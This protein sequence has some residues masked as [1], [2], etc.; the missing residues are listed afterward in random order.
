MLLA[1]A[2]LACTPEIES[3]EAG[4]LDLAQLTPDQYE[5][6][7]VL[8]DDDGTTPTVGGEPLLLV[9]ELRGIGIAVWELPAGV[10]TLDAL[11]ALRRQ[12]HFEVVEPDLYR[13]GGALEVDDPYYAYQWSF[14]T[15]GMDDA[16]TRATG[17]GV[18]VA[19]ID[20]GIGVA[21]SDTPNVAMG[22][23]FV[24]EDPLPIDEHR[25][26]THVAG[27][28]AQ[29]TGNGVGTAGIA[30][31]AVVMPL[32]VLDADNRGR[33]SDIAAAL[34]WAAD[35][36]VDI[37]N[38]SLGGS[39]DS[40]TERAAI[41]Y[42]A[43]AGVLLVA[44]AGNS[45]VEGVLYPAAYDEVIAVG[46]TDD[47]DAVTRYSN[48]G[49][50]L[51][52]AAPGGKSGAS[53]YQ[54]TFQGDATD[55]DS[56][57]ILGMSG[58]SM[59]APHV[60]GVAALLMQHGLTADET[61]DA[62]QQTAVDV[63]DAGYDVYSG[64]GRVD[65]AAALEWVLGPAMDAPEVCGVEASAQPG[66]RTVTGRVDQAAT[67][68][69]CFEGWDCYTRETSDDFAVEGVYAPYTESFTVEVTGGSGTSQ[70]YG[71]WAFEGSVGDPCLQPAGLGG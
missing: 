19:V 65:A 23:D 58:T 37:A 56:Y 53:I 16:W 69:I 26:G 35:E 10:E 62:L 22:W 42:A 12:G 40:A 70:R 59:A 45:G 20:S 66:V 15:I 33:T 52:L 21:G 44:A 47:A 49:S 13:S 55:P 18:V 25:H 41:E 1:L 4:T 68:E 27:T 17:E 9:S 71:P 60:S 63:G 14:E 39:V 46:A 6:G 28:I 61:R 5:A 54:E 8:L 7:R 36:G 34:E 31:D 57:T 2:L 29:A 67:V 30:P 11:M 48:W 43:S 64:Y 32:R 38:L 3:V 51:E 24:G 50:Q